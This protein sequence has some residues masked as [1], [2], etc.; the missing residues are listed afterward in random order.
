MLVE[1]VVELLDLVLVVEEEELLE[2]VVLVV[3]DLTHQV[4]LVFIRLAV[5]EEELEKQMP[6]MHLVV[7]VSL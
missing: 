3:V 6:K 4:L 1:V 5:V 7:Q 2:L